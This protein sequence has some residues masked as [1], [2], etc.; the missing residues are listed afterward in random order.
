MSSFRDKRERTQRV[1]HRQRPRCFL[2]LRDLSADGIPDLAEFVVFKS[3][4]FVLRIEDG[5]LEG[6][7]LFGS[8]S[9]RA[10]ERLLAHII[11]RD[12]V[13]EGVGHFKIVSEHFV[14]FDAK[15]LDPRA[16]LVLRF[17]VH[18]PLAS[19]GLGLSEHVDIGIKTAADDAAFLYLQR[20]FVFYG[21]AQKIHKIPEVI[22]IIPKC[23]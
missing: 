16:L 17:E 14:V 2:D 21:A 18:Q 1:Q 9:L 22:H 20:R 19:L 3:I 8:V 5:I 13:L 6:F 12:H 15:I 10:D 4:E 7:E 23:L 11:R